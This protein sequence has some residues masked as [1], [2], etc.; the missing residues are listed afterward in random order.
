[1]N[2]EIDL[3]M[4]DQ[5]LA[6]AVTASLD[7]ASSS[8]KRKRRL[9]SP[10]DIPD[11]ATPPPASQTCPI[12]QEQ[13][14]VS[15]LLPCDKH[16]LCRACVLRLLTKS[17][18]P[19]CPLCRDTY[20]SI[21]QSYYNMRCGVCKEFPRKLYNV[22]PCHQHFLCSKCAPA[23]FTAHGIHCPI[24]GCTNRPKGRAKQ[25]EFILL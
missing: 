6:D 21:F 2:T 23:F 18:N 20:P 19:G 3:T 8:G 24:E 5:D 17:D 22:R 14:K 1:M 4:E 16:R 7:D 9:P 10:D 15:V 13:P 11:D 25:N 12:C